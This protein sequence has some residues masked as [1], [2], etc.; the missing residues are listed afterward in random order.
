MINP[1]K[2]DIG[3]KVIYRSALSPDYLPARPEE[4]VITSFNDKYVFVRYGASLTSQATDPRDLTWISPDPRDPDYTREGI[5]RYHNCAR[6]RDGQ[7]P[8]V[9]GAPHR[10]D[11]PRAR[12]D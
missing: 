10:C 8:C 4:G 6:C 12:N 7:L 1:T 2:A 11:W 9:Q 3:R 5:F